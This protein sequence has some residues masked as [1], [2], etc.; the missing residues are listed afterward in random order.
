MWHTFTSFVLLGAD[1]VT[2]LSL[3]YS[4]SPSPHLSMLNFTS[5]FEHLWR[6]NVTTRTLRQHP[7]WV[8]TLFSHMKP[9]Y[10]HYKRAGLKRA[11]VY[12]HNLLTH[13]SRAK[14][15]L[16]RSCSMWPRTQEE[17]CNYTQREKT[18]NSR[19]FYHSTCFVIINNNNNNKKVWR[20]L[21]L[22]TPLN[23]VLHFLMFFHIS[24]ISNSDS[25]LFKPNVGGTAFLKAE[26]SKS[27]LT[28]R[29]KYFTQ[30]RIWKTWDQL[31]LLI[32]TWIFKTLVQLLAVRQLKHSEDQ[33]YA[34]TFHF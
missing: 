28:V 33:F 12:K 14:T 16:M 29:W 24:E 11:A 3:C 34:K 1:E 31:N 10:C 9:W 21:L 17:S 15:N 8:I 19:G 30:D 4:N 27:T 32:L 25:L 22:V 5:M 26:T 6:K 2:H 13:Q 20:Q 7:V 18:R 23:L